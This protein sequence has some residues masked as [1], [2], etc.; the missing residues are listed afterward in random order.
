MK[1]SK[2]S[3]VTLASDEL[4]FYAPSNYDLL[5]HSFDFIPGMLHD[6]TVGIIYGPPGSGKTFYAIHLLCS[7]ALGRV[8]FG[9]QTQVGKGLYIGLE[10]EASIKVRIQAWCL[11]NGVDANPITY[12]LGKFHLADDSDMEALI[13]YMVTNGIEFVVIDT[14]SIAAA[15]VD[16][17][18]GAEMTAVIG[19][20]HQIKRETGACVIA[21]AH[22]GKNEKAG[23]RGHSSQLGNVD[24]TIEIVVHNKEI[25]ADG[26]RTKIVERDIELGTPRSAN[27]RKQRDGESKGKW[28]FTLAMHETAT[29]D[30]R[31]RPVRGPALQ[32]GGLEAFKDWEV[33]VAPAA[34]LNEHEAAAM[35]TL[36]KLIS[37]HERH[38]LGPVTVDQ[39]RKALKR[40]GWR[41]EAKPST[42]R[43]G[44]KAL[45]GKLPIDSNLYI[46]H[47]L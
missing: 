41:Q 3:P 26:K 1:K 8:V 35:K 9:E 20:L 42:W 15:G 19:R 47:G 44:F 18:S 2:D 5:P 43:M 10:G 30:A 17:I 29:L 27:V 32:E 7:T 24:T 37:L 36:S 11:Q 13:L 45:V 31:G 34:L 40:D 23:I 16:E 22:T 14:L 38:G 33:E 39:F 46:E 28:A 12:A 4:H 25:V 21:L 6:A